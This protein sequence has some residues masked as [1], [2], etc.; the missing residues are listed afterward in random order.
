MNH[1][2]IVS[3]LW[4][5]ADLIGDSFKRGKFQDVILPL[6]VLRRLECVLAPTKEMVLECQAGLQERIPLPEGE[7]LVDGDVVPASVRA[8]F[9]REVLPAPWPRR[10]D[11]H[12]PARPPGR[13]GRCRRLRDQLQPLLL[14]LHPPRPLAEIEAH[15]RA[16]G[17]DI[18]EMLKEM[19]IGQV[20]RHQMSAVVSKCRHSLSSRE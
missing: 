8:F 16:V 17:K 11:R 3:F 5:V 4:S 6:T 7:D 15:I 1:G 13:S 9:A 18:L 20:G 2:E 12:R 10:L 14:S 19:S